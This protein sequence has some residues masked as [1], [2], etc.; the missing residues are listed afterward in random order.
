MNTSYERH[1]RT[2][3]QQ[4][5]DVVQHVRNSSTRTPATNTTNGQKLATSQ[6]LDMSRCWALAL[7]CG[8]YVVELLWACL[9]EVSIAGVCSRW[10]GVHVVEFVTC[11]T[12]STTCCELVRW[13]CSLLVFVAGVR[14]VEFG[15]NTTQVVYVRL[16]TN[17][18][19]ADL[20]STQSAGTVC[21]NW[22]SVT[23]VS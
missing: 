21:D 20:P 10:P 16:E 12:T 13:W 5:V 19:M 17:R 22:E 3:S 18:L 8:K 11:C 7:R 4:V 1:Q 2:S 15:S 9:S 23:R 14:V 6:H